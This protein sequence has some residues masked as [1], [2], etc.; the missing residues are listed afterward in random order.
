MCIQFCYSTAIYNK[1]IP[2]KIFDLC[3][4]KKGFGAEDNRRLAFSV[5]SI[6]DITGITDY[7]M[8]FC[9]GLSVDA[10]KSN[11]V[12]VCIEEL[13]GNIV[14]HGFSKKSDSVADISVVVL[15]D[16]I[17][18]RFKDNCKPFNPVEQSDL[19]NPED[20]THKIGL[21]MVGRMCKSME[22]QSLLG[23]NVFTIQI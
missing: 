20:I 6:E 1:K 12:A 9:K 4:I 11:W 5:R 22:Y 21:R 15:D 16:K 2:T 14:K 17:L 7:V 10:R 18:I 19:F 13:A 3:C 23:L 8:D